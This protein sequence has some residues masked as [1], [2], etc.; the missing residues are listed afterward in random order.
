[1][2]VATD[3]L[4]AEHR[5]IGRMLEVA[6]A[7][8]AGLRRGN[9]GEGAT[10]EKLIDFFKNFADRCHHG[11]EE[12]VLFPLLAEKGV[13]VQ[14]GPIG[15]MLNEHERGRTFI[16]QM[17]R[18][19]EDLRAGAADAA[20]ALAEAVDG[21]VSLL[22]EHIAKEDGVLFP[23]AD[24][25]LTGAEQLE[26]SGRFDEIEEKEM[27][28]GVHE[29]YHQLIHELLEQYGLAPGSRERS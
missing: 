20:G 19:L 25:L 1:V 13:P 26:L 16:A 4:R 5:A 23:M 24:R 8:A 6:G 22:R 11:K 18:G 28:E 9:T 14:N 3:V 10:L 15:V 7:V 12:D 27:G 17:A 29:R 21:Y 2:T